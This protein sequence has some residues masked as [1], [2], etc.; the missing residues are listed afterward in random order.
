MLPYGDEFFFG[1]EACRH[2]RVRVAVSPLPVLSS[3]SMLEEILPIGFIGRVE[4]D[5]FRKLQI[6]PFKGK[7]AIS[8]RVNLVLL[9][10]APV[11]IWVIMQTTLSPILFTRP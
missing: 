6:E 8:P 2:I 10:S 11:D 3:I 5:S 7:N 9:F 4:M 1:C